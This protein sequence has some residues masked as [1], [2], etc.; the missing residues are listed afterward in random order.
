MVVP[1][2]TILCQGGCDYRTQGWLLLLHLYKIWCS[3]L[4]PVACTEPGWVVEYRLPSCFVKATN[5]GS[6]IITP[7][8]PASV[9]SSVNSVHWGSILWPQGKVSKVVVRWS[10]PVW[11]VLKALIDTGSVSVETWLSHGHPR[12][13]DGRPAGEGLPLSHWVH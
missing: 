12:A 7:S 11:I 5:F 8:D 1:T 3:S 13:R 4:L 9:D 6:E 10:N 2:V